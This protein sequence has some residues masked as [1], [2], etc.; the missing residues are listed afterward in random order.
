VIGYVDQVNGGIHHIDCV[1]TIYWIHSLGCASIAV[2]SDQFFCRPVKKSN[3]KN[4]KNKQ[5]GK[6]QEYENPLLSVPIHF[7]LSS[8]PIFQLYLLLSLYV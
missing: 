5:S 8:E 7:K 3:N 2:H 1:K 4:A 6:F